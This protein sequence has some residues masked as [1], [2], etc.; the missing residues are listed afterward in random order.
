MTVQVKEL[1]SAYQQFQED[2]SI[3]TL[4]GGI[5]ALR[6]KYAAQA[7]SQERPSTGPSA[8][9]ERGDLRLICFDVLSGA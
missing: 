1:R 2:G 7:A 6:E 8:R 9:I 5:T 4:L 3:G